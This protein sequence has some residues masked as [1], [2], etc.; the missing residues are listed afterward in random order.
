MNNTQRMIAL[1]AQEP[2]AILPAA[3]TGFVEKLQAGEATAAL[4]RDIGRRTGAIAVL[5]VMGILRQRPSGIEEMLG[6]SLGTTYEGLAARLRRTVADP[7]IKAIVLDIDSPG[8]TAAGMQEV[9]DELFALRGQKPIVAVANT[10]AASA[11]YWIASQADELIVSP[12]ATVGSIGV[13][14]MHA[15]M[16]GMAEQDGVKVTLF[17][18]GKFKTLGHPFEPMTDEQAALVQ[19]EIDTVYAMFANAVARGRGVPA[20]GVKAGFGQGW[21]VGAKE[22][23]KLGMADRVATMRETL[24]RLGASEDGAR[25]AARAEVQFETGESELPKP[26]I[27]ATGN[28]QADLEIEAE[29]LKIRERVGR[30]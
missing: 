21:V 29:R 24:V 3:L 17:S 7:E 14:T 11:A 5:P 1:I 22:A 23:V 9:A 13:I 20:A 30:A 15:D 28:P 4:P 10:L 25:S 16:T 26:I 2:W 18:A 12:S 8:G 27:R 6:F 19:A